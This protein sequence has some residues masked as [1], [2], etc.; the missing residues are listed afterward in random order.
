MAGVAKI[1]MRVIPE[2]PDGTREIRVAKHAGSIAIKGNDGST[3]FL[4]GNCRDILAKSIAPDEWVVHRHNPAA[5]YTDEEFTPLYRVRDLV[6]L[7]K[8]CG[9]YNEVTVPPPS[10]EQAAKMTVGDRK[11]WDARL[12][13]WMSRGSGEAR[14]GNK[15]KWTPMQ[16]AAYVVFWTAWMS[17][18]IATNGQH[19]QWWLFPA[20][21]VVAAVTQLGLRLGR[22]GASRAGLR[23]DMRCVGR[24]C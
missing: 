12:V 9:A 8:N 6:F 14:G 3:S 17:A 7:C 21:F 15:H 19:V 24:S 16:R 5:A 1:P 11:A 18:L 13:E 23:P 2:P 10:D 20:I 4:C 22:S